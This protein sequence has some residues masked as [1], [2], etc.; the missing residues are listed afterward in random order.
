[1]NKKCKKDEVV[2]NPLKKEL[3]MLSARIRSNRNFK[4]RN[5]K[6]YEPWDVSNEFVKEAMDDFYYDLSYIRGRLEYIIK[7]L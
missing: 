6:Y 4:I 2:S 5:S 1:M 7:T 3:C